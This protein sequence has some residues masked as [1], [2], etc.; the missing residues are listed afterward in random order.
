MHVMGSALVGMPLTSCTTSAL[1]GFVL[2]LICHGLVGSTRQH[3]CK[4]QQALSSA[5]RTMR[6]WSPVLRTNLAAYRGHLF[7]V[8]DV[9]ACPGGLYAATASA[10]RTARVWSTER[11]QSLRILAGMHIMRPCAHS[12]HTQPTRLLPL[13]ADAT[14]TRWSIWWSGWLWLQSLVQQNARL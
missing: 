7:P 14:S 12:V 4:H 8:W 11:T 6:L 2:L 10:D 3:K 5:C 9:A 1:L 13:A